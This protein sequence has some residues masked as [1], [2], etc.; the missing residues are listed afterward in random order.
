MSK[1]NVEALDT[2]TAWLTE[3]DKASVTNWVWIAKPVDPTT[4]IDIS[5]KAYDG[6]GNQ[7]Y[8]NNSSNHPSGS[9][10]D[11]TPGMRVDY[12]VTEQLRTILL[13]NTSMTPTITVPKPKGLYNP[14]CDD[15]FWQ[16][17]VDGNNLVFTPRF[18]QSHAGSRPYGVG[19]FA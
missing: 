8:A 6:E 17:K 7:V 2:L 12:T 3:D 11:L 5:L 14:T 18:R 4:S 1:G 10:V 19:H 15:S 13:S 16:M 9:A